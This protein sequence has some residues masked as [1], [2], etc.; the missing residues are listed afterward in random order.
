MRSVYSISNKTIRLTPLIRRL[1]DII[2]TPRFQ[3]REIYID[4]LMQERRNSIANALGLRL[5]CTDPTICIVPPNVFV[6]FFSCH[7]NIDF[8]PNTRKHKTPHDFVAMGCL[9]IVSKCNL[10]YIFVIVVMAVFNIALYW[11]MLKRD[12]N[13]VI[14]W[15]IITRYIL[16][17]HYVKINSPSLLLVMG[18]IIDDF[19]FVL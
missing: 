7:N 11:T 18:Y 13:R 9:W 3:T 1:C 15:S 12:S 16:S 17:L 5:S 14:T 19:S 10:C 4:G 2:I 8:L 6:L